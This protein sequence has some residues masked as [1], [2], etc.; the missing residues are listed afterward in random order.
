M[1]NKLAII[2]GIQGQD[3]S[4]LAELLL[5][6]GYVVVGFSRRKST[7]GNERIK[8]LFNNS[9]FIYM[10]GDVTDQSFLNEILIKYKPHEFYNCGAMS[11]VAESWNTPVQTFEIN[12]V[13]VIKC[14]EAIRIFSPKTKFLQCSSSEMFGKVKEIPQNE[15]TQFNGKSPYGVSKIASF[16]ITVNYR[17]SYG[18]FACN[19]I[20]F[21]HESERRGIEFVTKKITDA[22]ARIKYGLQNELVLGNINSKRDWGYSGDYV[23]AMWLMLQ[24]ENPD[25]YVIATGETHSVKEFVEESFKIA[26]MKIEWEGEGINEVG[27]INGRVVVRSDQKFYRPAEV[28]LLV[29]DYSKA[30]E[31]IGWYPKIK[32]KELVKIMTEYDLKEVQ[33]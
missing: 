6:K 17:E 22:V 29:G 11:F 9:N 8:H 23:G 33:S 31:K 20:C 30:K 13:G 26:G 21:N 7:D 12:T 4:F 27:K 10:N 5:E 18:I 24:Q 2:S 3:A 32:F 1:E 25:D 14:L 16:Y 19:S 28:E 15:K